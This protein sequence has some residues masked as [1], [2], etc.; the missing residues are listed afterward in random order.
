[1]AFIKHIGKQGD[2]K[3]A[4]VYRQVPGEDHMCLVVYPDT[5]PKAFHDT[6]MKVIESAPGQEAQ[7]LSDPLFRNL[8][9]DG[10]PILQTLHQEGM[11]KK[12]PTNQIVVTPNASSHVRLDELNT[13]LNGMETGDEATQKMAELDSNAGLIDPTTPAPVT[14]AV[15]EALDDATLAKQRIAQASTMEAE[16]NAMIA[17][18][19]RLAEEA[20]QLDP[21]LR[22]KKPARKK[23]AAKKKAP[24]AKKVS[25]S[26]TNT[27]TSK[28]AAE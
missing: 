1:M 3:V 23:A 11:I 8:L 20:Y 12:V 28:S 22:P 24:A 17:E 27:A 16:A 18:S 19:K 2:R 15:T 13:I 14:E 10:R 6:V 7:D 9:P 26:K 4:I 21:S 5:L 25:A